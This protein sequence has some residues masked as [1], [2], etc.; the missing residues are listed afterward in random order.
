MQSGGMIAGAAAASDKDLIS[1][2]VTGAAAASAAGSRGSAF[3]DE[4]FAASSAPDFEELKGLTDAVQKKRE[5]ELKAE[6]QPDD[7][8]PDEEAED[9]AAEGG[10]SRK[11]S[12]QASCGKEKK[13]KAWWNRDAVISDAL[14][15]HK[16]WMLSTRESL[17]ATQ[18]KL[19][20]SL[21]A[22][23]KELQKEVEVEIKLARCR[24]QALKLVLA[25]E[26]KQDP[27]DSTELKTPIKTSSRE[28]L[29][30]ESPPLSVAQ[31]P[32]TSEGD[33]SKDKGEED[34]M[35]PTAEED[36]EGKSDA[37]G[38]GGEANDSKGTVEQSPKDPS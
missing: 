20:A 21:N 34:K 22:V 16:N 3:S 5:E 8:A 19:E 1:Q 24:R 4:G 32:G 29:P 23:P 25:P 35:D 14:M 38:L 6:E 36:K 7:L 30:A 37:A 15:A 18:K 11:R 28:D 9:H 10:R 31:P 27:S 2:F 33:E 17:V 26:S 13:S 12:D